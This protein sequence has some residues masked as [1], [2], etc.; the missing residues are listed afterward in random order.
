M[1]LLLDRL[2]ELHNALWTAARI[3]APAGQEAFPGHRLRDACSASGL[4][5]SVHRLRKT[6]VAASGQSA[7]ELRVRPVPPGRCQASG[8]QGV[9]EAP[10]NLP[11]RTS[12]YRRAE[13]RGGAGVRS[14]VIP[15]RKPEPGPAAPTGPWVLGEVFTR[16]GVEYELVTAGEIKFVEV[17]CRE[18]VGN[19]A[20]CSV[21]DLLSDA[22][23][24]VGDHVL[25]LRRT[26]PA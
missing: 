3:P 13:I 23:A 7:R 14:N 21:L 1:G 18:G 16:S 25:V 8:V 11:E 20:P 26:R 5:G 22:G 6:E 2:D 4:G 12:G 9:V 17:D 24:I 19:K 10:Q 15:L